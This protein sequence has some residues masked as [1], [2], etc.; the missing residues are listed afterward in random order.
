M[1]GL[2]SPS[3]CLGKSGMEPTSWDLSLIKAN[4]VHILS[5][6]TFP[7][8]FISSLLQ[9]RLHPCWHSYQ[10][11]IYGVWGSLRQPFPSSHLSNTTHPPGPPK[12]SCLFQVFL[13]PFDPRAPSSVLSQHFR[14]NFCCY[15]YYSYYYSYLFLSQLNLL[16]SVTRP[17]SSLYPLALAV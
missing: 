11:Q 10:S 13:Y 16:R 3:V 17:R 5:P 9:V 1:T 12:G 8:V 7:A 2:S 14:F 15:S 4:T 6:P